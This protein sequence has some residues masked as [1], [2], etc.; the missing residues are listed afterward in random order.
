[1]SLLRCHCR[2]PHHPGNVLTLVYWHCYNEIIAFR[3]DAFVCTQYDCICY[4]CVCLSE[5]MCL[6]AA[7]SFDVLSVCSS[8][9][10]LPSLSRT[11]YIYIS[12]WIC[13]SLF[14]Y[15]PIEKK[16]TLT[17]ICRVKQQSKSLLIVSNA[18]F[19]LTLLL[20]W[21]LFLIF[22]HRPNCGH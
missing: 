11:P 10:H 12:V 18:I 1:M 13:S 4:V 22:E 6:A 20:F 15:A 14:S 16:K 19:V 9:Y 7:D 21:F 8:F 5:C 17:T 2:S 3:C